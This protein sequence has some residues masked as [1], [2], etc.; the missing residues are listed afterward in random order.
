MLWCSLEAPRW[1]A[2]NEYHNICFHGEIKYQYFLVEKKKALSR[3]MNYILE[4]PV[5]LQA[6]CNNPNQTE[7]IILPSTLQYKTFTL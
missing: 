7:T 4:H 5:V 2:S 1:G 3:A 6:N